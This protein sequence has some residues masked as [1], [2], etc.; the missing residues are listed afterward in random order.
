[1]G[2]AYPAVLSLGLAFRAGEY[3]CRPIGIP[4]GTYRTEAGCTMLEIGY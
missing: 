1:V 4:H 3:A 2:A